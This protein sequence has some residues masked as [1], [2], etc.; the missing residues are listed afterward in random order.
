M[1]LY[2]SVPYDV[3]TFIIT[4]L[5]TFRITYFYDW[6]VTSLSIEQ[7]LLLTLMKFKLNLRDLDLATRFCVSRPTISNVINTFI[8]VL[9]ELFFEGILSRG[10]PSLKKCKA[11]M[12]DCFTGEFLSTR[13]AIDAT[14]ITMD[15]P[16]DLDKQAAAYSNYKSRH[17]VKA[18]TGVAPNAAL[19]YCSPLY[20]GN[21]SDV[22]IVEHTGLLEQF[23]PGDLILADKGFTLHERLPVGV[24]LNIPPFLSGKSQFTKQ[25]ARLCA[26]IAKA[27]I[28]VER[29]NERLKNFEI[30][31]HIP[32]HY[33]LLSTKIFQICCC[34]VNLQAP[35]LKEIAR[36]YQI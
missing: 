29:A 3:F 13:V 31:S 24:H 23:K 15:V 20:P 35:L 1:L 26:K 28:H 32:H 9:H 12:P 17:T 6:N 21:T 22:A 4:I 5:S 36:K 30:L 11:L 7:Q 33:R 18:V 19:V 2:T 25:E 10:I 8:H 27:R 34:L 14:E 16:Q